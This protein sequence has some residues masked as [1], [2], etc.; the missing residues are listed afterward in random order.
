VSRP[1]ER[2]SASTPDPD[3]LEAPHEGPDGPSGYPRTGVLAELSPGYFALVM[4]TGILAIGLD[5]AGARVPSRVMLALAVIAYLVL[6]AAYIARAVRHRDRVGRDARDPE[7][8]FAYFTIVAGTD[9]LAVALAGAG[10]RMLALVLLLVAFA[11]WLVLGYVLPW[12]VLMLRDGR[13][14]LAR[15]NGTWFIWS[16]ASQS[17]AVGAAVIQ[18]VLRTS[19]T[20][21]DLAGL[22]AVLAWSV[23]TMLYVLVAVLVV[24][25]V[26]HFGLA[27][28]DLEPPYWVAMGALAIAVVAG[29]SIFEMRP[30]PMVDAARSLIGGSVVVFWCF[31]LWL[32][33]LLT[34]IGVW[35][36][37]LLRL[38]LRYTPALWSMVFPLGMFAVAS[39]RLGAAEGLP[40]IAVLGRG[41]VG[42]ALVAWALVAAG[43]VISAAR[44]LRRR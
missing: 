24:L 33:P 28:E 7:V 11:I 6:A 1:S 5:E 35:R 17:L 43:L 15:A 30:T 16:V 3:H 34:G 26:V 25:R 2:A 31:A 14:I 20:V 22:L 18:P 23:G 36:H 13:P 10:L 39:M 42:V 32:I 4:A 41:F 44:A 37:L 40:L 21:S 19:P 8:A 38:P 29:A 12:Q 27:P 9:V